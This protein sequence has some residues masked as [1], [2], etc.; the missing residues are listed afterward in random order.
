MFWC[1]VYLNVATLEL[2]VD[3]TILWVGIMSAAPH[4]QASLFLSAF[5][6]IPAIYS[7]FYT[8]HYNYIPKN[9]AIIVV[10]II[11]FTC[12]LSSNRQ[13]F[14]VLATPANNTRLYGISVQQ[15]MMSLACH[16][17]VMSIAKFIRAQGL[18][19]KLYMVCY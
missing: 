9:S 3:C 16:P 1:H 4:K 2:V 7:T 12:S 11:C 5:L 6:F 17:Y 19:M 8:F 10:I 18:R 15:T 14:R 13:T